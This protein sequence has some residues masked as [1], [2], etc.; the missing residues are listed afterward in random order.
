M[1]T[2]RRLLCALLY[3]FAQ[4]VSCA[5][6]L[7]AQR[8]EAAA[9]AAKVASAAADAAVKGLPP[10]PASLSS[11]GDAV[12]ALW[13]SAARAVT[14]NP[15]P[16]PTPP[17]RRRVGPTVERWERSP[18][19]EVTT[20]LPPPPPPRAR[21]ACRACTRGPPVTWRVHYVCAG[22]PA[23]RPMSRARFPATDESKGFTRF[24]SPTGSETPILRTGFFGC[25]QNYSKVAGSNRPWLIL[26]RLRAAFTCDRVFPATE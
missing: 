1:R 8:E 11:A 3:A 16:P 24:D 15:A 4:T 10:L 23:R 9:A 12:G 14:G 26:A 25:A 20:S 6:C 17:P 2:V 18:E 22:I 19:R 7:Q 5:V 21:A 13:S